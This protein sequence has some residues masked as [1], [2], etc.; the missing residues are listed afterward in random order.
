MEEDFTSEHEDAIE[1]E[2]Q[3]N[4]VVSPADESPEKTRETTR[5]KIANSYIYF[6]YGTILI[7]LLIGLC[8]DF[9]VDDYKDMLLTVSAVLSGPLGFIIGY[10]FK[11]SKDEKG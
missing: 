5:S 2:S 3:I 8:K 11:A 1:P 6:F 9:K 7:V 10:Y 4:E